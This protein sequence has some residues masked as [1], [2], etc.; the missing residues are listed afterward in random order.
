MPAIN[1]TPEEIAERAG[2]R[3]EDLNLVLVWWRRYA[4]KRDKRILES[5][6]EG[7]IPRA[8]LDRTVN[9]LARDFAN[10]SNALRSG[11]LPLEDWQLG[12][13]GDV[14]MAHL[15]AAITAAGGV[16]RFTLAQAGIVEERTRDQLA[17]LLAFALA[18]ASGEQLKDGRLTRR[19]QMYAYS[20]RGTYHDIER[21]MMEEQG[22]TEEAR[23]RTARDSCSDCIR[24]D[25]D[26][27][28][29]RPIG[30]LPRIGESIC[31]VNCQCY[32]AYRRRR[33]EQEV[34]S[35]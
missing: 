31:L 35:I 18:V 11:E 22:Y 17:Y 2:V 16:N 19:A 29:W 8:V 24:F 7:V 32:F 23:I 28:G 21:S 9:S 5:N 26:N 30:T 27:M 14:E 12:M 20:S 13:A 10:R 15:A 34:P 6:A 3:A 4:S 25:I 1:W 33:G